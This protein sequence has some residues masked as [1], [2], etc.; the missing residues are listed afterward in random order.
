MLLYVVTVAALAIFVVYPA[1]RVLITPEPGNVV[2]VL[3]NT[4]TLQA[5]RNSVVITLLSTTSAS[6]LGLV[7]AFAATRRDIP[8]RNLFRIVGTLPLFAPPFMVAFAYVLV[9][10]RQG[11]I[12]HYLF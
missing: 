4:R 1:V 2:E 11:L 8:F 5:G 10:G 6:L 7:F 3:T 9:F 12:T